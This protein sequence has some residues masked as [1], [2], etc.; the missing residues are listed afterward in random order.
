MRDH[1][2][3]TWSLKSTSRRQPSSQTSPQAGAIIRSETENW[4]RQSPDRKR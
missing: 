2:Q 3:I 4:K 1:F